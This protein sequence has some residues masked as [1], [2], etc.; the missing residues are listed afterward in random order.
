[1]NAYVTS[2]IVKNPPPYVTRSELVTLVDLSLLL[3]MCVCFTHC[4]LSKLYVL[5]I[6]KSTVLFWTS[7]VDNMVPGAGGDTLHN[8]SYIKMRSF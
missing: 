8:F 2:R 3:C 5:N 6:T 1:M 4:R 7:S